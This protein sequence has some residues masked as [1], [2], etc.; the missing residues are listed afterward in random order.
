VQII[1]AAFHGDENGIVE[2]IDG[3]RDNWRA[4]NLRWKDTTNIGSEGEI[5]GL[6]PIPRLPGYFLTEDGAIYSGIG[7]QRDG[8]L[9]QMFPSR[10][11]KGYEQ[12]VIKGKTE[13]IHILMCET[14]LGPRPSEK[15]VARHLN[16]I[17]NDNRR[18]NIAWGTHEDNKQ[19]SILHG[20]S[21]RGE[22]SGRA[23]LTEVDV[24]TMRKLRVEQK[25]GWAELGRRFHVHPV[26]AKYAVSGKTWAHL[27]GAIT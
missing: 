19:D 17:N 15:H 14:F 27:P 26:T 22:T 3:N 20:T 6:H 1:C 24:L 10:N 18:S 8:Q 7:R 11:P 25:L 21:V 5:L 4:D 23:E 2:F 12:V 13:K 16:G 9:R